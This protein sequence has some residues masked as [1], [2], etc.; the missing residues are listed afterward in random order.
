MNISIKIGEINYKELVIKFLPLLPELSDEPLLKA[1][2]YVPPALAGGVIDRIPQN[3]LDDIVVKLVEKKKDSILRGLEDYI[4]SKDIH[5]NL[6]DIKV[7][8]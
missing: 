1:V 3:I 8:K 2:S 4:S 5:I 6:A 7:E